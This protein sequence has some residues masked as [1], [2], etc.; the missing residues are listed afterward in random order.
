MGNPKYTI[1]NKK[2]K[3][4]IGTCRTESEWKRFR[5]EYI[6]ENNKIVNDCVRHRIKKQKSDKKKI[7]EKCDQLWREIALFDANWKCEK[8]GKDKRLEIHHL[9]T[10]SVKHLRVDLSNK[11]C[12]CSGCHCLSSTFSFHKTPTKAIEWLNKYKCDEDYYN[13]LMRRA[14]YSQKVDWKLQLLYL[15]KEHRSRNL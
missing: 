7:Q 6:L 8:C 15:E 11:I 14:S 3:K 1:H 13:K 4:E 2:T 12:L 10:R 9:I 5:L